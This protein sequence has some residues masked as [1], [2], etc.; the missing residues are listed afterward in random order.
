METTYSPSTIP[1]FILLLTD[2]NVKSAVL[3]TKMLEVEAGGK[4]FAKNLTIFILLHP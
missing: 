1:R 3:P 4:L 2:K